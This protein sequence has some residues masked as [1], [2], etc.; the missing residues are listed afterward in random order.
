[1]EHARSA[2]G[3]SRSQLSRAGISRA[4]P[5]SRNAITVVDT[6]VIFLMGAETESTEEMAASPPAAKPKD[7][8]LLRHK[9]DTYYLIIAAFCVVYLLPLDE[10]ERQYAIG[11]TDGMLAYLLRHYTW[12]L[13][14]VRR[15][16]QASCVFLFD[17]PPHTVFVC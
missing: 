9:R 12:I 13:P 4:P 3:P 6:V 17:V 2:A 1:M 5:T 14:I 8:I 16:R 10:A 15:K 11:P 7:S